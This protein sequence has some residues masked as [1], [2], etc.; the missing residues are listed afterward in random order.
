MQRTPRGNQLKL[1]AKESNYRSHNAEVVGSSP[2]LATKSK[3]QMRPELG[4]FR[5]ALDPFRPPRQRPLL[6]HWGSMTSHERIAQR[7][8]VDRPTAEWPDLHLTGWPLSPVGHEPSLCGSICLPHTR[9]SC[10]F[11]VGCRSLRRPTTRFERDL[12]AQGRAG[13]QVRPR[14]PTPVGHLN[15]LRREQPLSSIH[16]AGETSQLK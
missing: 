6:W 4:I 14:R 15:G 2:T 10:A 8:F 11:S 9:R 1:K 13:R 3:T 5:N 16:G 7:R 12:R